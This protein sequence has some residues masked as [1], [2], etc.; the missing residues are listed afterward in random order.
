MA[1]DGGCPGPRVSTDPVA[2]ASDCIE[3][4]CGHQTPGR[5]STLAAE[6]RLPGGRR[7]GCEPQRPVWPPRPAHPPRVRDGAALVGRRFDWRPAA[8][9]VFWPGRFPAG[10]GVPAGPLSFT[11]PSTGRHQAGCPSGQRE[12]SVKP[13]ASPSQ[14]RILDLPPP[15]EMPTELGKLQP[16]LILPGA[17]VCGGGC[18]CAGR[19]AHT[20]PSLGAWVPHLLMVPGHGDFVDAALG[21]G[22]LSGDALGVEAQQH[23]RSVARPLG[24]LGSGDARGRCARPAQAGTS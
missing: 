8:G 15:V 19:C 14:V 21:L 16:A 24:H 11:V 5:C 20:C 2:G 4:Q 18:P 22:L 9:P 7:S 17:A 13:S 12:R 23:V 1:T 10:D 3:P 6:L